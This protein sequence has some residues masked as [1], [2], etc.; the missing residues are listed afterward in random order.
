MDEPLDAKAAAT[1]IKRVVAAGRIAV[2]AHGLK[3]IDARS[4]LMVDCI[5]V[6]RGGWVEHAEEVNGSW[7]YRVR[8]QR[9]CVVVAFRSEDELVVVTAWRV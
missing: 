7:R 2:S 6:L 3:Q 8:T 9:F 1:R 5:S 4:I